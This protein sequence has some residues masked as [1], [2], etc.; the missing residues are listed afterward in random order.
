V[1]ASATGTAT[2]RSRGRLDWIEA[3]RGLAAMLVVFAHIPPFSHLAWVEMVGFGP[4]GVEFFFL[5]SGFI[6]LHVHHQD[7]G[8][9]DRLPAYIWRRAGRI[10]STYWIVFAAVLVGDQILLNVA[11]R[12]NLNAGFVLQEALLFPGRDL[13]IGPAWTLRHE[14]L[15]YAFFAILMINRR[16]GIALF[17]AWAS[18]ILVMLPSSGFALLPTRDFT[19]IASHH[20]NL[21]FFM[22]MAMALAAE[23][24]R[25]KPLAA[26]GLI[27]GVALLAAWAWA[28]LPSDSAL[29]ALG[30]KAVF[31]A[32]LVIR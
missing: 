8:Q 29:Q 11:V 23:R 25:E 2:G 15:F 26:F 19:G 4:M 7:V 20:Y 30:Y 31:L 9:P 16:L 12:A 17:A 6:M 24:K 3:G 13:L 5:L 14:L 28:D 21:D 18:A 32:S 10:F 22:G 1:N 27:V